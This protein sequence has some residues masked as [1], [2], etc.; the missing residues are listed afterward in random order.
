[1]GRM[2]VTRSPKT[3]VETSTVHEL[4]PT[5]AASMMLV[6]LAA[7]QLPLAKEAHEPLGV[8]KEAKVTP[9]KMPPAG[10]LKV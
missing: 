9:V 10:Q 2:R 4:F 6:E 7:S 1:M 3:V 5:H 8:P